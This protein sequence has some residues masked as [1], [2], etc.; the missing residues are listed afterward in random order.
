MNE[1]ECKECNERLRLS[2][3]QIEEDLKYLVFESS[4]FARRSLY[5][6]K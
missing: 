5:K 4:S 1:A 6:E 2:I 3:A